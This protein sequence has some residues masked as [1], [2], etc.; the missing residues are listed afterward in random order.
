[1]PS[2]AAQIGNALIG[3]YW[4]WGALCGAV[5]LAALAYGITMAWRSPPGASTPSIRPDPLP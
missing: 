5:S 1:M 2:D 4:F 3:P